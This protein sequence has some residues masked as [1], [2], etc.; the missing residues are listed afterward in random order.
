MPPLDRARDY[1]R[2]VSSPARPLD[3]V[4][5]VDLSSVVAGPVCTWRLAEYG[6]EVV[7]V[8]SPDGDLMRV[9][10]GPSPAGGHSG[11]YLHLNRGKRAVCLDLKHADARRA[12]ERVID[13]ADVFVSNVRPEALD[14][15]E[16]DAQRLRADRPGLIHC[17]ITGFGPGG[18]YRG[19]P[20]YDSV[21]QG[22]AGVAGLFGLRDGTP[23]YVPLLLCDQVVGEIAAGAVLAAICERH[24]TGRG[25]VVEVPMFETMAALVLQ[26][27]LGAQSFEPPLGPAGD[28]RLLAPDNQPVPTRDGWISLTANTD[29]QARS[30]LTAIRRPAL[31]DDPRFCTVAARAAHVEEWFAL[32]RDALRERT[33][34][35]WLAVFAD[36]DVPAMAC[37]TPE[38]LAGDAHLGAVHLLGSDLHPTEGPIRS[39]RST[40]LMDGREGTPNGPAPPIGWDTRAVLSD[41]G[42]SEADIDRLIASGAAHDGAVT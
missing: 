21:I 9:L 17:T 41:A 19:R 33:T 2:R 36:A 26:Q 35:E 8:E 29:V 42:L 37:Q 15:L 22:G 34:A 23:C 10:G 31:A 18:P 32:R 20:A 28:R 16:L 14:R 39:I 27:H 1:N 13:R 7:K 38:G 25:T 3:G 4:R 24:R 40:I 11:T 6:A 5:V 30:L 12:L